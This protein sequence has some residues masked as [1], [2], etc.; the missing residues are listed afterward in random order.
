M[1]WELTGNASGKTGNAHFSVIREIQ[2]P[3]SI[4][5]KLLERLIIVPVLFYRIPTKNRA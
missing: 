3:R 4:S 1:K 2:I 5:L